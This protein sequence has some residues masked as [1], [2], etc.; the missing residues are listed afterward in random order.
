VKRQGH[1]H[2]YVYKLRGFLTKTPGWIGFGE[3][4]R[5]RGFLI[6]FVKTHETDLINTRS[7]RVL[8]AKGL[9]HLLPL[10]FDRRR[11]GGNWPAGHRRPGRSPARPRRGTERG[12]EGDRRVVLTGGGERRERPEPKGVAA[13]L[14][15]SS[16]WTRAAACS[17]PPDTQT[18]GTTPARRPRAPGGLGFA[19]QRLGATN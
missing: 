18:D 10:A 7:S 5:S 4:I 17:G 12:G 3:S 13:M 9:T 11:T 19:R 2:N 14:A 1:T 8:T 16:G 15:A 6:V